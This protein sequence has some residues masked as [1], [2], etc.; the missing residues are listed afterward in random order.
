MKAL[1]LILFGVFLDLL[2]TCASRLSFS[3]D[4]NNHN[5]TFVA[6]IWWF[7]CIFRFYLQAYFFVPHWKQI[8]EFGRMSIF[9]STLIQKYVWIVRKNTFCKFWF[10]VIFICIL[11]HKW[12]NFLDCLSRKNLEN[13]KMYKE[14]CFI[15]SQM[16]SVTQSNSLVGQE[17]QAIQYSF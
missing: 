9:F 8:W 1:F 12:G 15:Y 13:I 10:I 3:S 16:N 5:N 11:P 6:I 17:I 2:F 4:R 7:I 14:S